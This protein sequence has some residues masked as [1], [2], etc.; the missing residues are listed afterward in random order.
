[1]TTTGSARTAVGRFLLLARL[2]GTHCPKTFGIRSVVLTVTDSRWRHFYFRSTS[3]SSAL[4]VFKIQYN[5]IIWTRTKSSIERRIWGAAVAG[6][7]RVWALVNWDEMWRMFL[8]G[9]WMCERAI[10]IYIWHLTFDAM[11]KAPRV[12]LGPQCRRLRCR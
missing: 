2:S 11:E 1:M 10:Q 7:A 8:D 4:E 5:T 9:V 6:R 3:V 12:W